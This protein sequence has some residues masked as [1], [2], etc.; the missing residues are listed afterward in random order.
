MTL[1]SRPHRTCA[2]PQ[3]RPRTRDACPRALRG[4]RRKGWPPDGCRGT[5]SPRGKAAGP[6][7]ERPSE[8][9]SRPK[10]GAAEA[11]IKWVYGCTWLWGCEPTSPLRLSDGW[12]LPNPIRPASV[13]EGSVGNS[14]SGFMFPDD[15]SYWRL[16]ANVHQTDQMPKP[17][18][19][20]PRRAGRLGAALRLVPQ[21]FRR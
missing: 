5:P 6:G 12:L 2:A 7:G 11:R 15:G 3:A 1:S 19:P 13:A 17:R 8:G 9:R 18:L 16:E 20:L 14:I 4:D 21:R 10:G